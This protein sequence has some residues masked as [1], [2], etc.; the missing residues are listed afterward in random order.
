MPTVV[1]L[2]LPK[3]DRDTGILTIA[4]P[5][6]TMA[7]VHVET[8]V[9]AGPESKPEQVGEAPLDISQGVTMPIAA[10]LLKA[11]NEVCVEASFVVRQ[12]AAASG[13][14]KFKA[15][16]A[17]GEHSAEASGTLALKAGDTGG[18]LDLTYWIVAGAE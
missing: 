9:R 8:Y 16:L 4:K 15:E 3:K 14:I 5:S 13:S 10:K 1:E 11:A 2:T 6:G 7:G 18:I 17:V 12:P